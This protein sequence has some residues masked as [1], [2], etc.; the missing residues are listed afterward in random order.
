MKNLL[1]AVATVA[2]AGA[3]TSCS[4]E[5]QFL[6][7]WTMANPVSIASDMPQDVANATA[8]YTFEFNKGQD[9]KS[10]P[11]MLAATINLTQG[12][13]GDSLVIN[14]PYEVSVSGT[15]TITGT[16]TATDDD[17]DE[18][19][20]SYDMSSL[21]VDVDPNGVAFSQNVLTGAQRPVVD[22]LTT[23]TVSRWESQI[24]KAMTAQVAGFTTIDDIDVENNGTILKFEVK[25]KPGRDIKYVLRRQLQGE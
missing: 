23:A 6:G 16:W 22:S 2:V 19:V 25:N 8:D 11:M 12:V 7:M 3:M 9:A 20:I 13:Q 21:S 18:I 17:D 4:H 15:A 14:E 10:G 24:K 1:L 5:P